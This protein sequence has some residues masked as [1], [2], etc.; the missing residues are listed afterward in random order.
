MGKVEESYPSYQEARRDAFLS[1][2]TVR[3]FGVPLEGGIG[4]THIAIWWCGIAVNEF[5][6]RQGT[7][8]VWHLPTADV[9]KRGKV[10]DFF[11]R[12]HQV[13]FFDLAR[14][15]DPV[16]ESYSPVSLSHTLRL[17]FGSVLGGSPLEAFAA[18]A[19]PPPPPV[20][21]SPSPTTS[22]TGTPPITIMP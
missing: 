16:E 5:E 19:P 7:T 14:D 3:V 12:G 20:T 6:H 10:E 2:Y 11:F 8:R 4:D 18:A 9:I 22:P 13:A 15:S 1:A 21:I 17:Y